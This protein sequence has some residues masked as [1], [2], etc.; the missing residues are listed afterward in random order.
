MTL[1]LDPPA[2]WAHVFID[3]E[4]PGPKRVCEIVR[5]L[6]GVVRADALLGIRRH[7]DR[8][9]QRRP[10][11]GRRHRRD[12]RER[13]RDRHRDEA[14]AL[15]RRPRR[16]L[17]KRPSSAGPSTATPP[18]GTPG[19]LGSARA[20]AGSSREAR[21]GSPHPSRLGRPRR[22]RPPWTGTRRPPMTDRWSCT[23][24]RGADMQG[25]RSR[26]RLWAV[27]ASTAGRLGFIGSMF[28]YATETGTRLG[29]RQVGAGSAFA[30][31]VIRRRLPFRS[32]DQERAARLPA[33]RALRRPR[34]P[35]DGLA[36]GP[37]SWGAG[38]PRSALTCRCRAPREPGSW[39]GAGR[40]VSCFRAACP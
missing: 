35:Q 33:L 27:G 14:R 28:L 32:D 8:R 19:S 21:G 11:D 15:D 30:P 29:T 25:Q 10:G 36:C 20:G 16:G 18:A 6:D 3:T 37:C 31:P 40:G 38:L 5:T 13:R 34:R 24:G 1:E 22:C 12:R 7:R 9:R 39:P 4:N 2:V 17:M 23:R 26:V